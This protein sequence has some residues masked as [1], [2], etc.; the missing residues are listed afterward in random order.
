[1]PNGSFCTQ[2][3]A[4]VVQAKRTVQIACIRIHCYYLTRTCY[5]FAAY[6]PHEHIVAT[7]E[8]RSKT[9]RNVEIEKVRL[10]ACQKLL[11]RAADCRATS[12]RNEVGARKRLFESLFSHLVGYLLTREYGLQ[13]Y[14]FGDDGK[15]VLDEVTLRA[16]TRGI[17]SGAFSS[18]TVQYRGIRSLVA[19]FRRTMKYRTRH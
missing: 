1:M 8:H 19:K 12:L 4:L 15:P 18:S 9:L 11:V 17:I 3:D 10:N 5:F 6:S 14:K 7:L 2:D 13:F 16:P